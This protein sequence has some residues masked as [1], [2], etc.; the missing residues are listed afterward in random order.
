MSIP[1]TV[2]PRIVHTGMFLLLFGLVAVNFTHIHLDY[3][4]VAGAKLTQVP[5]K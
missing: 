4:T 2:Y 1:Y 3:F 5:G